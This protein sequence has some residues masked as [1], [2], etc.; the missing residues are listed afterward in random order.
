MGDMPE[1]DSLS[2]SEGEGQGEGTGENPLT[3]Q[4]FPLTPALSP[5]AGEREKRSPAWWVCRRSGGFLSLV[6]QAGMKPEQR[7]AG[8]RRI[9]PR[10]RA[11]VRRSLHRAG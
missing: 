1:A 11:R 8:G 7:R 4:A 3:A 6:A 10:A 9:F 5:S 2:P